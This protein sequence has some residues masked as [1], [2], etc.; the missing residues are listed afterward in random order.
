MRR[1]P[2]E[3]GTNPARIDLQAAYQALDLWGTMGQLSGHTQP[4][5]R[6]RQ[7]PR[8]L[9]Q[10]IAKRASQAGNRRIVTVCDVETLMGRARVNRAARQRVGEVVDVQET[11]LSA[12]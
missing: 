12:N 1:L 4:A 10:M 6:Q 2:T 8:G 9:L 3:Y 7:Q 11:T 5:H